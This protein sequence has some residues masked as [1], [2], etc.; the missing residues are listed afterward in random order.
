MAGGAVFLDRDGVINV[1]RPNYV[2]SWRDFR[3]IEGALDALALLTRHD[4]PLV[5][6]SNQSVIGRGLVARETLDDI[7]GRMVREIEQAGGK[8]AAVYCCPHRPEE[9]CACRKPEPGLLVQAARVLGLDLSRSYMIG[10]SIDDVRAGQ[11][12]GCTTLLVRTGRGS[13]DLARLKC[14]DVQPL[15]AANLMEAAWLILARQALIDAKS[16][17]NGETFPGQVDIN[18]RRIK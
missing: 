2:R 5:V 7:H 9:R 15:V 3:F 18:S 17:A 13:M 4:L 1:Y 8:V 12:V 16:T 10:D 6:V 14:L 11:R